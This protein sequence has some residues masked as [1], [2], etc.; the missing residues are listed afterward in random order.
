MGEELCVGPLQGRNHGGEDAYFDSVTTP[1]MGG[2]NTNKEDPGDYGLDTS[3]S[4]N[5][6]K[7][8]DGRNACCTCKRAKGG[9]EIIYTRDL[10]QALPGKKPREP[11]IENELPNHT[12]LI[13]KPFQCNAEV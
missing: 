8:N 13:L 12:F 7:E 11:V 10:L 3:S 5:Y 9:V 1:F 6:S 4:E 2:P